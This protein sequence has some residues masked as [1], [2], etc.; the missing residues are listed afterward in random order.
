[1]TFRASLRTEHP[2]LFIDCR[3]S[4]VCVGGGALLVGGGMCSGWGDA[5][6]LHMCPSATRLE[7]RV[8]SRLASPKG[9]LHWL[10]PTV[11]GS[12]TQRALP[13]LPRKHSRPTSHVP[14]PP[15]ALPCSALPQPLSTT[16]RPSACFLSQVSSSP[17]SH[18]LEPRH[19]Y[20]SRLKP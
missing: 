1:M 2:C 12:E 5:S 19:S 10:R 8:T 3:Q 11:K 18:P 17:T 7:Q 20:I 4:C 6:L 13:T 14:A 9:S 15:P 16:T